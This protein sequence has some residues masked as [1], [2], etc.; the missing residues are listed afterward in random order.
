MKKIVSIFLLFVLLLTSCG[1]GADVKGTAEGGVTEDGTDAPVTTA[2]EDTYVPDPSN[3]LAELFYFPSNSY[4]MNLLE[5]S[6]VQ[7]ARNEKSYSAK[8]IVMGKRGFGGFVTNIPWTK[9]YVDDP[10]LFDEL[11]A[12]AGKLIDAGLNLWLYDELGYP[13][14]SGGGRTVKDNPEYAC[15]GVAQVTK[16]GSG[17][18]PFTYNKPDNVKGILTAYAI[19]AQGNTHKADVTESSVSFEGVSGNWTLYIFVIVSTFEGSHA[20]NSNWA[21]TDWVCEDY[22][23]L[24]DKNAVAEFINN[25]YKPYAEKFTH[26]DKAV[27]VFTDEP[28]LMEVYQNTQGQTFKYARISWVDGF[29]EKFEEM[30]GYSIT[31]NL[32]YIFADNSDKSKIIRVNFRQTVAELVSENYFGQIAEF[33]EA[34]GSVLSGHGLLEETLSNH[35]QYYGDLMQSIRKMGIPGVD[36]LAGDPSSYMNT[37]WPIFMAVKY[38]TSVA[39]LKGDRHTMVEFCAPDIESNNMTDKQKDMVWT[40]LNLM[41]FHGITQ[42]NSYFALEYMGT[43]KRSVTDYFGRLSYISRSAKWDGQIGM[44]YP[45]NTNQAY[46]IPSYTQNHNTTPTTNC[47]STLAVKLFQNQRD[48]TVVDNEFILEAEI[49]D[50]TLTNGKVS[51]TA[52]CMP[53]VQVMP[54]EVLKK[55]QQFESSGGTVVW[56]NETPSLPD[57]LNDI[58]EFKSLTANLKSVSE[59]KAVQTL[60]EATE[61]KLDIKKT[62]ST[63]YVGRYVLEDAP[64]YWLFNYNDVKKDLTLTYEGATAFDIYDPLTGE[65]TT[66]TGDSAS[67]TVDPHR[68]KIVIVR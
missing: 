56:V 48:F 4:R 26:F 35:V 5:H 9:E 42:I 16:K 54:I 63:L 37:G 36:A 64:M 38:V 33:C 57:D 41:Y 52:I 40:T 15:Q 21:C 65:I 22:L 67:V 14:G 32:H 50:G 68:A 29:A 23:N 55:L 11:S 13:S 61:D 47:I 30:H 17:K 44:Y 34:N 3:P 66:V 62:T 2:P 18:T 60:S 45:I 20:Q 1:G 28:S 8:L 49:K 31:D 19:D 53:G 10:S 43:Q 6:L 27:G 51:F 7:A 39:T 46:S 59:N 24:M 58:D 12:A 25:T